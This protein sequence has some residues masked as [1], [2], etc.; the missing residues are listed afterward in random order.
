MRLQFWE[1]HTNLFQ[2]VE[3]RNWLAHLPAFLYLHLGYPHNRGPPFYYLSMFQQILKSQGDKMRDSGHDFDAETQARFTAY[4]KTTLERTKWK[5]NSHTQLLSQREDLEDR[6][7]S[8]PEPADSMD[9]ADYLPLWMQVT[10][11]R[12]GKAIQG[13][14]SFRYSLLSAHAIDGLTYRECAVRFHKNFWTVKAAYLRMIR[15]LRETAKGGEVNGFCGAVKTG[16]KRGS[17][18]N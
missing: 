2:A 9:F 8:F 13:L 10:D 15:N 16:K 1:Y 12:L 17:G 7:N 11:I 14:D 6:E 18:S 5:Y 4:L 3:A